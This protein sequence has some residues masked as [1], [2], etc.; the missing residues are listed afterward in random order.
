MPAKKKPTDVTQSALLRLGGAG[1][2]VI[3]TSDSL[4]LSFHLTKETLECVKMFIR[5]RVSGVV[6]V[7]EGDGPIHSLSLHITCNGK[8]GV[9]LGVEFN[10]S[11]DVYWWNDVGVELDVTLEGGAS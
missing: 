4:A 6:Q 5:N 8:T 3:L 2:S 1:Q 11:S 7:I 10:G 9:D